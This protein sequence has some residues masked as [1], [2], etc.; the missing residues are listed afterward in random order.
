MSKQTRILLVGVGGQGIALASV[1]LAEAAGIYDGKH[2]L[3]TEEYGVSARGG[4]SRAG[5][6]I[7]DEM[8]DHISVDRPDILLAMNETAIKKCAGLLSPEG[9]VIADAGPVK[10]ADCGRK[11]YLIPFTETARD[12]MGN[13]ML[14]AVMA[15]AAIAVLSGAVS[16]DALR[17]AVAKRAPTLLVDLNLRALERGFELARNAREGQGSGD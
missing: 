10:E 9:I 12:E 8:I 1:M 4:N 16:E 17:K 13:R 14:A 15:L 11:I 2:V 3:Q 7:S 6:I 5:V